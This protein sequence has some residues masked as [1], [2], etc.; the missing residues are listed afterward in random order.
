MISLS[1]T[2][3]AVKCPK[4][5]RIVPNFRIVSWCLQSILE[6]RLLSQI[7]KKHPELADLFHHSSLECFYSARQ[8]PAVS[9]E[10]KQHSAAWRH[11]NMPI[12]FLVW[13]L[14]ADYFL[15]QKQ[16]GCVYVALCLDKLALLV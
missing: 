7:G 12:L 11:M 13:E 3:K 6:M 4:Y 8:C 10:R 15:N 16:D 1:D 14:G 2:S 9:A 5:S